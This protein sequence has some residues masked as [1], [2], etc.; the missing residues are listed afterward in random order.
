MQASIYIWT[1]GQ[2]ATVGRLGGVMV[3]APFE[4]GALVVLPGP[5]IAPVMFSCHVDNRIG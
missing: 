3:V 2:Y 1:F 4:G 5:N